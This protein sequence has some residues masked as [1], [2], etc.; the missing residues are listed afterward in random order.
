[1]APHIEKSQLI[2]KPA[3]RRGTS[4]SPSKPG[5]ENNE[6]PQQ[7]QEQSSHRKVSGELPLRIVPGRKI[8]APE[9][10]K[11]PVPR[12][13]RRN[14]FMERCISQEEKQKSKDKTSMRKFST[15]AISLTNGTSKPGNENDDPND[16]SNCQG[17][18][19]KQNSAAPKT[20]AP[21]TILPVYEVCTTSS[22]KNKQTCQITK[23]QI[24]EHVPTPV[25][26]RKKPPPI[27]IKSK[28]NE[29]KLKE[30]GTSTRKMSAPMFHISQEGSNNASSGTRK[31]YTERCISTEEKEHIKSK[32]VVKKPP[33]ETSSTKDAGN[34]QDS[35]GPIDTKSSSSSIG[36]KK[37]LIEKVQLKPKSAQRKLSAP[38]KM[39]TPPAPTTVNCH[40]LL[41]NGI[42]LDGRGGGVA[43]DQSISSIR[44]DNGKPSFAKAAKVVH[45]KVQVITIK[46]ELL[47]SYRNF[48]HNSY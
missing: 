25:N 14:L 6:M 13:G 15:P 10:S 22:N 11:P 2:S 36:K 42:V 33:K 19:V 24:Q 4:K 28:E 35:D 45:A 32:P 41:S 40:D 31:L 26:R 1:M 5:K 37:E 16:P 7:P 43:F 18:E 20:E 30:D 46:Q 17:N 8:S 23:P 44:E 47:C 12:G 21:K 27:D 39:I 9:L 48:V 29:L 3:T 34:S 38:A